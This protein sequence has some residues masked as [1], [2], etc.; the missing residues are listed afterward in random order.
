MTGPLA[1]AGLILLGYLI[2][3]VPVGVI[4]GR[5]VGGV[6]LRQLGSRRTGATNAL[7]TIGARWAVLVFALDVAKGVVAVLVARALYQPTGQPS[8][9]MV[10]AG[11]ALA[12]VVGHNWSA[13]IGFTGG[14]GVATTAGGLLALAPLAV[15]AAAPF[16]LAVSWRTRYV[17][18]GSLTGAVVAA[19][20]SGALVVAG[21]GEWPVFGYALLAGLL[22]VA[23]HRDNIARLREG[24]ERKIGEREVTRQ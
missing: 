6:D 20:A 19:L 17:S 24:T 9:E 13:F 3:A 15:V 2:G 5:L 12:A 8:S 1:A 4:V 18:A 21:V 11:A 23:S 10:A 14:R 16:A 7:R 22:V